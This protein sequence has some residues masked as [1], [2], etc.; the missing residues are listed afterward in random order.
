MIIPNLE[1]LAR[2]FRTGT[3]GQDTYPREIEPIVPLKLPLVIAKQAR[4]NAQTARHWLQ[5]R[6]IV[7]LLPDD[8]R[9]LHGCLVAHRGHGF[10][11][12][13]DTDGPEE[14]R[15]TIAHEVAHFLLDYLLPRHQV[16]QALGAEMAEVL[17]GL[18]LPT[19]AER[20]AAI[21]SHV[22]LSAH[23]HLLPRRERDANDDVR[24][25]YAE[26]R[27]DRL[28]LELVAPQERVRELLDDLSPRQVC[29]LDAVRTTLATYFGLPTHAFHNIIQRVVRR[30]PPSFI[31]DIRAGLR[32][33]R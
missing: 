21:L 25:I 3:D 19:P 27:A 7:I 5:Q 30:S 22:R 16:M 14:Q 17:D 8:Q 20:A 15:L 31:E 23:V 6:R 26:D 18:R 28:A 4:I 9:D 29:T 2:D 11:F 24:V 33:Q 32:Q 1:A 12:V 10:I 13:S